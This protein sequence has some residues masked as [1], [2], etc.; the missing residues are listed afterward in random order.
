MALNFFFASELKFEALRP[1]SCRR[2]S[3]A[4]SAPALTRHNFL[5]T[6]IIKGTFQN[7]FKVQLCKD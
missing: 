2:I 7:I 6:L 1:N 5:S 3:A 4:A